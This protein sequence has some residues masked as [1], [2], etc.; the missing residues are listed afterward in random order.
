MDGRRG[1][2]CDKPGDEMRRFFERR[3][4]RCMS[5]GGKTGHTTGDNRKGIIAYEAH[6]TIVKLRV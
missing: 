4:C 5:L 2:R 6:L 1:A 3:E